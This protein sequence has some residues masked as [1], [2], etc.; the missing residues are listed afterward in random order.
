METHSPTLLLIE[1][2][3]D[4]RDS[5]REILESEGYAV[6][7]AANGA[8]G[9][10]AL[11]AMPAPSLILLDL[12]MPVMNGTE[13]LAEQQRR[14]SLSA[15]PVVVL[16]ADSN[17]RTGNRVHSHVRKPIDLTELLLLVKEASA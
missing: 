2:E 9:L 5:L 8:E 13:F 10:R 14:P 17:L 12:L 7:T 15:I 3:P 16:S 4:I 1:D 11:E 6:H